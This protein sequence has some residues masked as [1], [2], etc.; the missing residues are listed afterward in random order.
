MDHAQPGESAR[1]LTSVR[2]AD[3]SLGALAKH[4]AVTQE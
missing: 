1:G 3:D 4:C 2:I